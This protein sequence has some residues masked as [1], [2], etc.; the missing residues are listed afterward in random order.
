MNRSMN[1]G[2][3]AKYRRTRELH[4]KYMTAA[5]CFA[6]LTLTVCFVRA[7]IRSFAREEDPGIRYKYY[8]SIQ[9]PYGESADSIIASH[10]DAEHFASLREFRNEV[11][12]INHLQAI[13]TEIYPHISA[14]DALILPYYDADF[15]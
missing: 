15:R 9:I 14:G 10:F 4:R 2:S 8:S 5:I 1:R 6:V 11:L 13:G 12:Q 7:G 3:A